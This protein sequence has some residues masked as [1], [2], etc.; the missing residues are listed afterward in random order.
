MLTGWTQN[1]KLEEIRPPPPAQRRERLDMCVG[2]R[3]ESVVKERLR[4]VL[5]WGSLEHPQSL[6]LIDGICSARD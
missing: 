3:V 1:S 6:S 2:V 5:Y 4:G